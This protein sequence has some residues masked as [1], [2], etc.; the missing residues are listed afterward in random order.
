[1]P[2]LKMLPKLAGVMP[3]FGRSKRPKANGSAADR[4]PIQGLIKGLALHFA[5]CCHP[6]PG[7]RIVGIVTTGKG[8]TIH[9]IDCDQLE[10]FNDQPNRWLDL[11]WDGPGNERT[12]VGRVNVIV[13][14]EPGSLGSL[15]TVIAR[16]MGNI[17]NL[18]ITERNQDFFDMLVD[19][20]VEDVRHLTN[21]IAALRAMPAINYVERARN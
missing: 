15:T 2:G 11:S 19:V 21:I 14:N 3:S 10:Q 20:E 7:D 8:V 18:K 4:M 16:N 13:A 12:H 9:T 1:Y 17:T 6:L 5:R